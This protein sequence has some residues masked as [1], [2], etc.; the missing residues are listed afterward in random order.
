[1]RIENFKKSKKNKLRT[2]KITSIAI[3][4]EHYAFLKRNNI[5]LSKLVRA[6]IDEA[7][8]GIIENTS[9]NKK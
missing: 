2:D 6:I 3:S 4:L 9:G 1:M 7:M 8:S 5:D